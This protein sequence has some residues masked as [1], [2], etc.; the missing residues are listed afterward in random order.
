MKTNPNPQQ[1]VPQAR[2]PFSQ[3]VKMRDRMG[4]LARFMTPT[5]SNGRVPAFFKA[6]DIAF[7]ENGI[8]KDDYLHDIGFY[9][10]YGLP[11]THF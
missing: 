7:A 11:K 3:F 1:E 8:L 2:L 9:K 6:V 4:E 10:S 5:R